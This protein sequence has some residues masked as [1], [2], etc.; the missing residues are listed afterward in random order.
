MEQPIVSRILLEL[1]G[2]T[3]HRKEAVGLVEHVVSAE[4]GR[5]KEYYLTKAGMTLMYD[6]IRAVR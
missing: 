5:D 6:L 1:S 3:R 2:K 4:S